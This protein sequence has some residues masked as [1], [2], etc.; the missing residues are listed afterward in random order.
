MKFEYNYGTMSHNTSEYRNV[1][2][3][4]TEEEMEEWAEEQNQ[5]GSIVVYDWEEVGTE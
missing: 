5:L 4:D 3:F 1:I 2:S